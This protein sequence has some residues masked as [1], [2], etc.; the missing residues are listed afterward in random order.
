MSPTFTLVGGWSVADHRQRLGPG[1]RRWVGRSQARW[2]YAGMYS[3]SAKDLETKGQHS[4]DPEQNRPN[5]GTWIR[6][7]ALETL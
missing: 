6:W 4:K 5:L 3:W 1:F 2:E 7:G